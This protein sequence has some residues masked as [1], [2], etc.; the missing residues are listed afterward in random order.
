MHNTALRAAGLAN[1]Y[2]YGL[3]YVTPQCLEQFLQWMRERKEV[4]G[5]SVTIP[6]KERILEHLDEIAECAA[7]IG[8]V[9]TVVKNGDKL[10]GYNTDYLGVFN[11]IKDRLKRKKIKPEAQGALNAIILGMGGA[12]KAA[13]YALS[14]LGIEDIVVGVRSPE[15]IDIPYPVVSFEDAR[16]LAASTDIVVNATSIGDKVLFSTDE[17][18]GVYLDMVYTPLFTPTLQAII[19]DTDISKEASEENETEFFK[20]SE[21]QLH[22]LY[23]RS[24]C[25][26]GLEMLVAQG[27]RQFELFTGHSPDVK[28]MTEC[29]VSGT[30]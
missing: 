4:V 6:L 17:F 30:K 14:L 13:L 24:S 27:V 12:G 2:A 20:L 8:S 18:Q 11:P 5:L 22:S 21:A 15:K 23:R 16:E 7:A 9:N 3:M 10:C 19:F 1:E 29:L 26:H 28:V 25:I